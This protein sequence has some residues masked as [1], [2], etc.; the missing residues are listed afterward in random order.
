VEISKCSSI[1]WRAIKQGGKNSTYIQVC[2]SLYVHVC[3]SVW[4]CVCLSVHVCVHVRARACMC[5]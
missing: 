4:V 5:N 3:V 2:V 1:C